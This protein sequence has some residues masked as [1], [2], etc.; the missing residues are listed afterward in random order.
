MKPS[1]TRVDFYGAKIWAPKVLRQALPIGEDPIATR[2]DPRMHM[3][4]VACASGKT[5]SIPVG[6]LEGYEAQP[7]DI[8]DIIKGGDIP[9]TPPGTWTVEHKLT[10][11]RESGGGKQL[12]AYQKAWEQY[13]AQKLREYMQ[14]QLDAAEAKR[15]GEGGGEA[16]QPPPKHTTLDEQYE[17][18]EGRSDELKLQGRTGCDEAF[19]DLP[20]YIKLVNGAFC[21]KHAQDILF[22]YGIRML[23][24]DPNA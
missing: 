14:K 16:P 8:L 21:D 1:N 9:L 22:K 4:Q 17:I 7:P 18:A 23:D 20:H 5:Y 3:I 12:E 2:Y 24:C 15:K 6:A 13:Q 19:C 11:E 10:T